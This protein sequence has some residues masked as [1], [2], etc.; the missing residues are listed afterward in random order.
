MDQ[1]IV[2]LF[3]MTVFDPETVKVLCSA[4]EMARKS[5][6]D[7]GQP[8]IVNEVIAERIIVLAK[9]GERN[10]DKLC[11]GALKAFGTKAI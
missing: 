4:Y 2:N 1:K 6:H 5:L 7:T 8:D 11:D 10:P 3:Q 9:Q